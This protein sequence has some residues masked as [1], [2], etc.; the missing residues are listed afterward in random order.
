MGAVLPFP[1]DDAGNTNARNIFQPRK[2][3]YTSA[4]GEFPVDGP[5]IEGQYC[6]F[7]PGSLS[8]AD[9]RKTPV[10]AVAAAAAPHRDGPRR[11]SVIIRLGGL[12]GPVRTPLHSQ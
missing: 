4:V 6:I 12:S 11:V 8:S 2:Y 3:Y 1:P 9:K 10:V 7:L 5:T